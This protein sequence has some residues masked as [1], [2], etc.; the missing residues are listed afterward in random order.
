MIKRGGGGSD[1]LILD[2]VSKNENVNVGDTI[3][4]AGTLGGPGALPSMFPRGIPVGSVT[5]RSNNDVN[6]FKNIQV[7]PLVDFSS[8]QSVIV[9]VPEQLMDGMKAALVLFVAALLQL[10][11]ADGVPAVPHLEHRRSSRCSRSRCCAARSSA[12]SR[13]S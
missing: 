6:A 4:T 12:R 7:S 13:A 5:S 9:L 8:L 3:I 10:V 11:G 2:R 1:V